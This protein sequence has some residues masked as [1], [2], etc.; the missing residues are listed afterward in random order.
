MRARGYSS[1]VAPDPVQAKLPSSFT[2]SDKLAVES[3]HLRKATIYATPHITL[4]KEELV[5]AAKDSDI[6]LP[7]V[8]DSI[9]KEVIEAGKNSVKL[10]YFDFA[11]IFID[12]NIQ[13][14]NN[15]NTEEKNVLASNISAHNQKNSASQ[16]ATQLHIEMD[17]CLYADHWL[18]SGECMSFCNPRTLL[19]EKNNSQQ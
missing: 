17:T 11:S 6:L 16:N 12:K 18:Q 8:T 3:E 14:N 7:T 4:S 2:P 10:I 19:L 13:N 5:K 15:S 9:D 1:R